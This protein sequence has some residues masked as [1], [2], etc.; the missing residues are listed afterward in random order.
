MTAE[1]K[2]LQEAILYFSNP[3]NC[4]DYLALRRWPDGKVICP[5]CGSDKVSFN[6]ARRTWKCSKHHSKR[7]F[8]IKVGTVME[9][10]AIGLDKWLTAM[11]MI[12]NCKNGVSSCEI[13][14]NVRVTQKSAWFMLH[15]IRLSM[16][17]ETLGSK[18]SG[19]VEADETFIGGKA[20]N[21]HK[22]VKARRITGQGRNTDDKIMVMGILE[23]GGKIRTK[24]VADRK[25]QTLHGAVK[26]NVEAG[27][28]LFTDTFGAY[29][30]LESEFAHQIVDHA[31]RYVDGRVHTNGLEN[32]WSLLK[33]SL[34][35]TYVSVEPFHLFRYLDEQS[36]RYNFRG[37]KENPITDSE[38][39]SIAASQ[40]VGKRITFA[41]LTGKVGETVN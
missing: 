17:D 33:R 35:G 3:D 16:Q 32:F 4:I 19:E 22:N 20:R 8:S 12:L 30:G 38:R 11:W 2:S 24:I 21:M 25:Q 1:P 15:R 18:F 37:T 6:A 40:L 41:Q 36:F 7:E 10:S 23:R 31:L 9:D 29:K 27:S 26:A 34:G 5:G 13:A 28:E 39:F 14:K